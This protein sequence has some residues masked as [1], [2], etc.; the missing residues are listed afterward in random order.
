MPL[1]S[2]P[3]R[4]LIRLPTWVGDVVMATPAIRAVTS[5][6]PQAEVTCEGRPLLREL[7]IGLAGVD[8]F[9]AEP[10]K[11]WR[12]LRPR[13]S[14]LRKGR[15]DLA[16]VLPDSHRAALG[17][18]LA[19]I[20][21]RIGYQQDLGR[22][23]ML[24]QHLPIPQ[25][26]GK[27]RPSS[28]IERFLR[29]TRMAGIPDDGHHMEVP[30][31]ELTRDGLAE[32]FRQANFQAG[33]G[34][35]VAVPGAS[36]GPSKQWPP[37]YFAK[38][39]EEIYRRHG[40]PLVIAPSGEETHIAQAIAS[41]AKTPV[42]VLDSPVL[43][44]LQLAALIDQAQVCISNDTGPRHF[45]VALHTP[46]VVP[47]GSTDP[48]YTNHQLERQ[49]VLSADV[50]CA[51]CGLKVCPIDHRCMTHLKPKAVLEAVEELL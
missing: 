2:A 13:V 17:P 22:R 34:Y 9:L 49:R 16:V 36:F 21:H 48:R 11:R 39:A 42:L 28:M 38:V 30:I 24:T 47:I 35:A 32:R 44:L 45:A 3:A 26:N 15:F 46:V 1:A 37:E 4:I 5:A 50:D 14:A 19:R 23:L 29:L 43:G 33:A 51:P 27:P 25:E 7:V 10:G 41:S 31:D 18:F 12:D 6:Y 20:P 8:A 40:W